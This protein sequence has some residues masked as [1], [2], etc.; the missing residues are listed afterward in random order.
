MTASMER[1]AETIIVAAVYGLVSWRWLL[2]PLQR[3]RALAVAELPRVH[4]SMLVAEAHVEQPRAGR[5]LT[6][7]PATG[8]THR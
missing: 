6:L 7:V 2:V 5:H 4:R 3:R 1:L 8:P